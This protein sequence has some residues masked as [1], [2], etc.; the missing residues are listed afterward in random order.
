M[1]RQGFTVWLWLAWSSLYKPGWPQSHRNPLA[2]ASCPPSAGIKDVYH[3]T[4]QDQDY[5]LETCSSCAVRSLEICYLEGWRVC[6][7]IKRTC[8]SSRGPRFKFQH[9]HGSSQPS[10]SSNFFEHHTYIH[11]CRKNTLA[12][13]II[14]FKFGIFQ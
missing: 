3:H 12:H 4:W 5:L 11:A 8:Y 10:L 13:K 9:S 1:L 6:S 7:A 14:F 2:S